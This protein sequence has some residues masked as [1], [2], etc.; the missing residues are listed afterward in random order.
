MGSG[1]MGEGYQ[2]TTPWHGEG[3]LGSWNLVATASG[4]T[5]GLGQLCSNPVRLNWAPTFLTLVAIT[6]LPSTQNTKRA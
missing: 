5:I 4:A 3:F 2:A 1:C 6:F